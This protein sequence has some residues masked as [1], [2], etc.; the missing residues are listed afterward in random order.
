MRIGGDF[1]GQHHQTSVG[2]GF[3]G[4][5]AAGVLGKNGIQNGIG[6]LVGHFVWV[7]F[8]NGFGCEKKVVRHVNKLLGCGTGRSPGRSFGERFSGGL[9]VSGPALA[10]WSRCV[11][12]QVVQ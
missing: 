2:Q 5:A 4:H 10:R 11:V 7:A 6:N 3:G 9:T 1:T 8:R 12:P